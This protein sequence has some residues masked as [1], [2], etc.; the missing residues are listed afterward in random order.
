MANLERMFP[1]HFK[2]SAPGLSSEE[3]SLVDSFRERK[4]RT[5]RERTMLSQEDDAPITP[6]EAGLLAELAL[7]LGAE[8]QLLNSDH[9]EYDRL[10]AKT[11]S[12]SIGSMTPDSAKAAQ[13]VIF[14]SRGNPK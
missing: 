5:D 10:L 4:A 2:S 14:N 12:S 9:D 1:S 3:Q 11:S 6:D 8:G 13:G 7:K